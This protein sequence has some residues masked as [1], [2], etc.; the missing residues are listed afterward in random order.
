[1]SVEVDGVKLRLQKIVKRLIDVLA[2]ILILGLLWPLLLLAMFAIRLNMGSPVL[3]WQKRPGL[4]GKPFYVCK[5]RTMS[6][7]R[8]AAGN[9][10]PADMRL[11]R[12]GRLL[13]TSSLDELPQLWNVLKGDMSLVGPRPLLM[14]YLDRYTPEQARRHEAVPGITG[15]T[16][17]HGRNSLGWEKR[18]CLD[19]WYVDHWSLWLDMKILGLTLV[20]VIRREGVNFSDN[21]V[22]SP[23]MGVRGKEP[24]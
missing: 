16:Q 23:Y 22:S 11:T 20:K 18:F 24:E 6:D 7:A 3:F 15:W 2:A 14:E 9:L 4:H 21:S 13:R 5:L 10:L 17:V 8:D 19:V 12:L 1:M